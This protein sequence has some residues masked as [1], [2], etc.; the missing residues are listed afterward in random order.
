MLFPTHRLSTGARRITSDPDGQDRSGSNQ[1]F[2]LPPAEKWTASF[3]RARARGLLFASQMC[4]WRRPWLGGRRE[5]HRETNSQ[6]RLDIQT[7]LHWSDSFSGFTESTPLSPIL[8]A[9]STQRLFLGLYQASL[10]R[11]PRRLFCSFP[12]SL[13]HKIK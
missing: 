13:L 12:P 6:R 1:P 5:R 4:K 7:Q 9:I 8:C 2:A 11:H 3:A 10:P